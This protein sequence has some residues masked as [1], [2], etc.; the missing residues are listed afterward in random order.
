MNRWSLIGGLTVT[1]LLLLVLSGF[2]VWI[3][4]SLTAEVDQ[5]IANNFETIRVLRDLRTSVARIDAQYRSSGSIEEVNRSMGV[6]DVERA[7]IRRYLA[8]A[9]KNAGSMNELE[10]L[11]RLDALVHDYFSNYQ[12]YFELG[13]KEDEHFKLLTQSL[14]HNSSDMADLSG[15]LMDENEKIILARRDAAL[16][17][18]RVVTVIALGFAIFSLGIYILTSVRLTRAIFEPLWRLRDSIQLVRDRRFEILVPLEGGEELGQIATSFNEMA[19]ELHRYISETDE[20]AIQA[21]RVNRA[22]LEALPYPVYI[23]DR[24]FNV[25]QM[26]PRAEALSRS[27]AIPGALPGDVRRQIDAA[28]AQGRD[29]VNDDIRRAVRLPIGKN[30][31]ATEADYLAQTFQMPAAF[32]GDEGWGVLLVDVTRLRRMDDAK[33]RALSTLGHEVKT[34]V[35]GVR[36]TLQLLLEEK[37]GILTSEQRELLEAGRD[38]CERLLAILQSLLELAQLESG[39]TRMSLSPQQPA[40]LLSEA[41]VMHAESARRSGGAL[42]VEAPSSLPAVL[43]EPMHTLRVL[44]NFLTNAFKYGRPG[45][46][47]TLRGQSRQD[48]YVRLSVVNHSR[49]ALNDAEQA[50][51]F[52]PFFR[53]PG[54]SAEGTGLGL[55]ISR[56]I[57]T[58]HGGR[59]GVF[60]PAGDDQV[61][62]FLD[63]KIAG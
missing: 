1:L 57:A 15:R 6:F 23:V 28:A 20:R 24:E 25:R 30:G 53:R 62:F 48:G 37:L 35:A 19:G 40:E 47:I 17:K 63:L 27:L 51:V 32:A 38:D 14:G 21:N 44:G 42:V 33:T 3:T 8:V 43:A 36:M 55:A 34:P 7:Q 11:A 61:E 5:M 58:A 46:P 60:C 50:R 45:Q 18:G 54:E 39:R 13:P 2:C 10:Q 59:V 49:H 56:E 26:N 52:D 9:R 41:Q 16:A 31:S 29:V 22:I 4:R 12:K